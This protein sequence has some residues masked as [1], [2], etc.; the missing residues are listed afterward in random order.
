MVVK[1]NLRDWTGL[2][3]GTV[4]PRPNIYNY[5]PKLNMEC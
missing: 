2:H 1:G 3:I 5:E 4:T